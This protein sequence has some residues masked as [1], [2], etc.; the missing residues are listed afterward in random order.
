M[1][2]MAQVG[3]TQELQQIVANCSACGG[4]G[5]TK[6]DICDPADPRFGKFIPCPACGGAQLRHL[7][8]ELRDG[9][10]PY[11]CPACGSSFS[12]YELARALVKPGRQEGMS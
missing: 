12:R 10:K 3:R 5:L 1:S 9:E 7:G 6:P 2:D 4:L 11:H 8:A